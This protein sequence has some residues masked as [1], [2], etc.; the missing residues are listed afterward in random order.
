MLWVR[1]SG[2]CTQGTVVGTPTRAH[3]EGHIAFRVPQAPARP[4]PAATPRAATPARASASSIPVAVIAAII[5]A[6][7]V[8]AVGAALVLRAGNLRRRR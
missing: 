6:V 8:V 1:C 2:T 5:V 4:S 3:G 7:A